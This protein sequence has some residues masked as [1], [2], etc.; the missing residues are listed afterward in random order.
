MGS[1]LDIVEYCGAPRMLFTDF[2]LGNPCGKPGDRDMQI[3]I[4]QRGLRL[5]EQ[6]DVPGTVGQTP[7]VWGDGVS[8]RADYARVDDDNR[9]ELAQLGERR[10]QSQ[11]KLKNAQ[12]HADEL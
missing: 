9:A 1:A 6:A 8:W 11:R 2:P 3:D 12:D 10:R 5:L 4:A 7:Y